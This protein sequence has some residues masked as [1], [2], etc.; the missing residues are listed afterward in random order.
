M[1]SRTPKSK[2]SVD[3]DVFVEAVTVTLVGRRRKNEKKRCGDFVLLVVLVR[4]SV[5]R[6][7][8]SPLQ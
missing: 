3:E 7:V 4:V 2:R 6:V 5:P 8:F 1:I